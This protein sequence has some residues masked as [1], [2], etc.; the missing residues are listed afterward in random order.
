MIAYLAER[1][2]PAIFVPA[3][4]LI[5][6]VSHTAGGHAAD[7]WLLDLLLAL[8][9]IAQFRLWDDLADREHDRR[10]HPERVLVRARTSCGIRDQSAVIPS[11]DSIARSAIV[12][13]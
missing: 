4:A 12:S 11:V 7:S 10:A 6:L 1:L 9:L 5:A 8:L 3:A 13:S 2:S